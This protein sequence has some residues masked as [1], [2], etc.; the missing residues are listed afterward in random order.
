MPVVE[1]V[2]KVTEIFE[3]DQPVSSRSI[4]RELKIDHKSFKPFTQ[5]CIKKTLDVCLQH[6]LTPKHMFN[7]ISF[8]E[9]LV[10]PNETNPFLKRMVNG[11][12][13]CVTYDNTGQKR[14]WSHLVEAAQTV[15]NPGLM[16]RKVTLCIWWNWKGII[17]YE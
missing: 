9:A 13:K 2:N 12:K 5:S 14:S 3:V 4:A 8:C 1:N 11:D 6:Q 15:V 16:A 17:Y 7:R 10:K